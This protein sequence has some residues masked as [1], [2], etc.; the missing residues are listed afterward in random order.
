INA[1]FHRVTTIPLEARFM[2]KLD[3]KCIELIQ[4]VRKKGGATREKTKLL[5]VVEKDTD[6]STRREIALKCLIINMRESVEDLI[7]EFLV[8]EKE[9]AEHILLGA[10]M[11]IF[12]I[13]NLK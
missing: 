3:E 6:I 4:V 13:G 9:E 12:I 7:Q 10:T 5:P 2:Q 1:E 8:S 11:A